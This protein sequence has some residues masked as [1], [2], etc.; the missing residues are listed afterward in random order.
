M[1]VP[2]AI[3]K[4]A[5]NNQALLSQKISRDA[6]KELLDRIGALL[7]EESHVLASESGPV[8]EFLELN[9]LPAS[10]S[11]LL[12]AHFRAFCLVLNALKI[13]VSA[14]QAATDRYFAAAP[15]SWTAG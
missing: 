3:E 15:D 7:I 13:W 9:V 10:F 1:D 12:P 8:R 2:T 4:I 14:E 5:A 11:D 6:F